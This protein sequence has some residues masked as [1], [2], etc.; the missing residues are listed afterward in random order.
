MTP[1]PIRKWHAVVEARDTSGLDSLLADDVVFHSPVVHTPQ[2]GKDVTMLYLGAALHVLGSNDFRYVREVCGERDAILEFTASVDG[3]H[4]NG[5]DMIHWNADGRIDDFKVMIRPL[6]A[7]NLLH[8]LM[9]MMLE[10]LA[11]K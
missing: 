3:I 1:E 5:V 10:Q 9:G 4:V 2:R 8:R 7:V 6:K 11:P